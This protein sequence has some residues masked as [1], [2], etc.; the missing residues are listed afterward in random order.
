MVNLVKIFHTY[1]LITMQNLVAVSH[2]L[3]PHEEGPKM[4]G[5][6]GPNPPG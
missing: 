2:T 4:W 6:P 1:T 5:T 3:F